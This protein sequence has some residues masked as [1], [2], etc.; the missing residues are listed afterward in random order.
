MSDT[1]NYP[2]HYRASNGIEAIDVVE[3]FGLNFRLGNAVTYILRAERKGSRIEDLKK[4]RWY[5]DRELMKTAP[6]RAFT[7][8][9]LHYLATPYTKY[10]DGIE[11]AY[12]AAAELT[13]RLMRAGASVY[14]PIAHMHP[15]AI[16]GGLDPLDHS[17][18]LP[19]NAAMMERA[20]VLLVAKLR[21]WQRS[22][23]TRHE[24]DWFTAA[25]KPVRYLCPDSLDVS[26]H[27]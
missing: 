12:E 1:V 26:E 25:K 17:I 6:Q 15:V 11:S 18:W 27:P 16:H 10:P 14:S 23:G 20:D 5:I 22:K 3:G 4:A 24:I 19:A 21:S 9:E 13:A 2:P 8:G 7:T